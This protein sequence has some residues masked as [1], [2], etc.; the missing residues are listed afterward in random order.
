MNAW[1]KTRATMRGTSRLGAVAVAMLLLATDVSA[2][3]F[4]RPFR[5]RRADGGGPRHLVP[6]DRPAEAGGDEPRPRGRMT[7]EERRQLRRDVHEAGRDLY[8]ERMRHGRRQA[9]R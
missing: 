7:P 2:Q 1:K 4:E 3:A 5:D 6:A 8:P 9:D